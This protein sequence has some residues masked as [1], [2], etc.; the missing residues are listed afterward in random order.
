MLKAYKIIILLLLVVSV[1]SNAQYSR[2]SVGLNFDYLSLKAKKWNEGINNYNT[3]NNDLYKDQPLFNSGIDLG[4]YTSFQPISGLM[5]NLNGDYITF[6]SKNESPEYSLNLKNKIF[7]F[8][9]GVDLYPF[10]WIKSNFKDWIKENY[11]IGFKINYGVFKPKAEID[12]QV[13]DLS[14]ND[15]L[16]V[17]GNNLVQLGLATGYHFF[18]TDKIHITPKVGLNITPSARINNFQEV[19]DKEIDTQ[20]TSLSN[21]TTLFSWSIGV[22]VGYSLKSK[23]PMCPISSCNVHFVHK[24]RLQ[25][26]Q[27]FRGNPHSKRQNPRYGEKHRGEAKRNQKTLNKP[28]RNNH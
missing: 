24:H 18:I 9:A 13:G 15:T 20:A 8:G 22:K 4:I 12:I 23:L 26:G 25:G 6:S 10:K 7:A 5:V 1:K 19:L 21:K 11:F 28:P 14:L 27:L 2:W 3:N 16:S 17:S